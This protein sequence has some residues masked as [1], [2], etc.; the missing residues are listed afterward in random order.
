VEEVAPLLANLPLRPVAGLKPRAKPALVASRG[1]LLPKSSPAVR[2]TKPIIVAQASQAA[3]GLLLDY[4]IFASATN[5]VFRGDTTYFVTNAFSLSGNTKIE[6]GTVIKFQ[7]DNYPTYRVW[8][9]VQGPVVCQTSMYRP[10]IFTAKDDDTMGEVISG[11]SG[12][13]TGS[14]AQTALWLDTTGTSVA[15]ENLRCLHSYIGLAF[16]YNSGHTVRHSQFVKWASY[17]E[18]VGS[19]CSNELIRQV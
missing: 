15:L 16:Y 8:L 7:K 18:S 14:Y 19:S 12:S 4:S 1:E 17:Q 13:P 6:G 10:A 9:S 5:F 3:P 11:S 2:S